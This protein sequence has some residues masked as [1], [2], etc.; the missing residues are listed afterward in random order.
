MHHWWQGF[1]IMASSGL[2]LL[3]GAVAIAVVLW[4]VLL[5]TR[6]LGSRQAESANEALRRRET[7]PESDRWTSDH[8]LEDLKRGP[9]PKPPLREA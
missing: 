4:V 7:S 3:L 9:G 2:V 6:R 1:G 5:G 8:R